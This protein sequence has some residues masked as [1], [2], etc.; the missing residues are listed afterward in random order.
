MHCQTAKLVHTSVQ[1]IKT[2]LLIPGYKS[3]MGNHDTMFCLQNCNAH[4]N[5]NQKPF[6][7]NKKN[8]QT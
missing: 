4:I 3:K 7:N 6:K 5:C 8:Q 2:M 1:E